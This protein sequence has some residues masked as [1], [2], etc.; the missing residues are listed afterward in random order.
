FKDLSVV[1][2]AQVNVAFGIRYCRPDERLLCI[3]NHVEARSEYEFVIACQRQVVQLALAEIIVSP[4][5]PKLRCHRK[6]RNSRKQQYQP[7]ESF[8]LGLSGLHC[9]I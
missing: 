6:Q 3:E 8:H 1:S 4:D 2:R 5:F 7:K 9:E